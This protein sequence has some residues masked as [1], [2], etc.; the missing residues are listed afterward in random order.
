MEA[1]VFESA[2]FPN[3]LYLVL[4]AGIW[5]AALAV[6][7]PGTGVLELLAFVT[8]G[9]AGLGTLVAPL[10]LWALFV[11]MLGVIFFVLSLRV[12]RPEIGLVLSA[13]AL[14]LGS[15]FLFRPPEGVAGIDPL[16]AVVVSGLTLGYFWLAVRKTLLSQLARPSIDISRVIGE[17]AEVRT[18][19]DPLGSVY[20]LGE[21]WTA[22]SEQPVQPG[23][24]VKVVGREGLVLMVEPQVL[25]R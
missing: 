18:P 19:L 7:S 10:N 24:N 6:V 2:L 4:V 3:L 23:E 1:T 9:L 14:S 20:A 11:L 21:M 17:M 8:L 5:I 12:L 15:I 13:A 22:R 16:L 25:K